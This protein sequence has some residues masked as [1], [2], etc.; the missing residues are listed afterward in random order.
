MSAK[1]TYLHQARE[2]DNRS[3]SNKAIGAED[4]AGWDVADGARLTG[5][6]YMEDIAGIV[7]GVALALAHDSRPKV[8]SDVPRVS[9]LVAGVELQAIQGMRFRRRGVGQI[10]VRSLDDEGKAKVAAVSCSMG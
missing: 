8:S 6:N 4:I 9:C 3:D 2:E 5:R 1:D 10:L 7:E